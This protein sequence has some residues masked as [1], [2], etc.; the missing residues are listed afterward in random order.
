MTSEND[1][2]QALGPCHPLNDW[3]EEMLRKKIEEHK[4]KALRYNQGKLKWS[5]VHYKSLEPMIR[6][7][8]YGSKKYAAW[9]WQKGLNREEI[10]ESM[11]RHLVALM[12][13]QEID[14]ESQEHHIG[15]LFCNCMFYSYFNVISE[16]I[17]SE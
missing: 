7:L 15:H 9:N 16:D 5:L 8:E 17:S 11:M 2:T 12:D 10:L 14:P 4:E 13:H 1:Q 3:Q 6:V